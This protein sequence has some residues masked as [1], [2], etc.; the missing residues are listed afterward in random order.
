MYMP[1][2]THTVVFSI[3][4]YSTSRLL[5]LE[6]VSLAIDSIHVPTKVTFYGKSA[7]TTTIFTTK[8]IYVLSGVFTIG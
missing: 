2:M 5:A 3:E 8:R 6:N 4:F 1:I 7:G